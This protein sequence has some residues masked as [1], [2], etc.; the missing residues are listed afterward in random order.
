[1][2]VWITKYALTKGIYETEAK[3]C[4]DINPDMIVEVND[5]WH[6]VAHHGNDWHRTHEAAVLRANE[7]KTKKRASLKRQLAKV[8]TLEFN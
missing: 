1:M 7:M 2:K 6:Q 4:F 8:E 3:D 5:S